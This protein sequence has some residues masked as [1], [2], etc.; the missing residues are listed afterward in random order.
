MSEQGGGTA[1]AAAFVWGIGSVVLSPCHLTSIPLVV[2]YVNR[3]SVS[4]VKRALTLSVLFSFGIFLSILFIGLITAFFGRMLG[5]IGP[6]GRWIVAAVFMVFGL[7][8]L[9]VITLPWPGPD[10]TAS[11]QTGWAGALVLGL[12]FG[13]AVGPCTFAYMA[14][15]LAVTFEKASAHLAHSIL[16]ILLYSA[17]HCG[18]I[19][20]AGTL[21]TQLQIFLNWDQKTHITARI[22]KV[23]GGVLILVGLYLLWKA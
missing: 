14:P 5:D 6:W 2:A 23:C 19:V 13:A 11:T 10:M 4:S 17:G 12:V 20:L 1:L 3:G 15:V 22:R 9:E 16:L 21:G 7:V 8:L 18:V